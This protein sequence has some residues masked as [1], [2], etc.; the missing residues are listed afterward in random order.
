MDFAFAS[1]CESSE[2]PREMEWT[3]SHNNWRKI[4]L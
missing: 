2:S 1:L 3:A 4:R